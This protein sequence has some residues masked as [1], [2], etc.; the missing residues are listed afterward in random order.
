MNPI[1][2]WFE[3]GKDFSRCNGFVDPNFFLLCFFSP[4]IPPA[5]ANTNGGELFEKFQRQ[6]LNRE[7][8]NVNGNK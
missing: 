2:M 6:K 4:A 1:S 5:V 8:G 7:N 3:T